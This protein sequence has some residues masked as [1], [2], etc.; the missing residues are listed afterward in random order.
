M[1]NI[2]IKVI[3]PFYQSQHQ[4]LVFAKRNNTFSKNKIAFIAHTLCSNVW[5]LDNDTGSS[6]VDI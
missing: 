4:L 5:W 6:L 3:S 2:G 1:I